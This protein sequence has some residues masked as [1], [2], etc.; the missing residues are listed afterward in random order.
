MKSFHSY[1]LSRVWAEKWSR[2]VWFC[3]KWLSQCSIWYCG[4][5]CLWCWSHAYGWR[6]KKVHRRWEFSSRLF[7]WRGAI[8]W[9][10]VWL[11]YT[12]PIV[13]TRCSY[14]SHITSI[15]FHGYCAASTVLQFL[16]LRL[17]IYRMRRICLT[18]VALC[19]CGSCST[20]LSLA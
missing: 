7:W 8:V 20:W 17:P 3:S 2:I 19:C 15:S 14:R 11:Y 16:L 13:A 9:R 6:N 5:S 1:I 12:M 10:Y 18:L 4:V